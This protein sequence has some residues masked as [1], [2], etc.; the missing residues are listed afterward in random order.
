MTRPGSPT[1]PAASARWPS[2]ASTAIRP[3]QISLLDLLA[4]ISRVGGDYNALI[5]SAQERLRFVGGPQQLYA[6][7]LAGR[8]GARVHLGHIVVTVRS[9]PA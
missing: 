1:R 2:A 8:L 9:G 7:R 4:S 5:G 6:E 3:S